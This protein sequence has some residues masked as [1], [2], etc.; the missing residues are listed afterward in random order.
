MGS[1]GANQPHRAVRRVRDD[2]DWAGAGQI[3]NAGSRSLDRCLAIVNAVAACWL[4]AKVG[5]RR[6]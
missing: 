4:T 3:P 5:G 1:K 2:V 6:V